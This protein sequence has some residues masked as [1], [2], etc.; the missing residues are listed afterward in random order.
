MVSKTEVMFFTSD[1]PSLALLLSSLTARYCF[2]NISLSLS[3][4]PHLSSHSLCCVAT[5]LSSGLA[6]S[7]IRSTVQVKNLPF[8]FLQATDF[9]SLC[10][11]SAWKRYSELRT[12]PAK[13]SFTLHPIVV[14]L[15]L[16]PFYRLILLYFVD[17]L[18]TKYRP[19]KKFTSFSTF[20]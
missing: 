9:F 3:I 19:F 12:V 8:N 5:L 16:L 4:L 18:N 14:W 11:Q 6:H 13:L 17:F 7:N 1:V 2:T 10:F 20:P 15:L